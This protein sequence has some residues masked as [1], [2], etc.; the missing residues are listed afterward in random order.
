[1]DAAPLLSAEILSPA[2]AGEDLFAITEASNGEI[3]VVLIAVLERLL[4]GSGQAPRAL[5][6]AS[7][8]ERLEHLGDHLGTLA[9][10]TRLSVAILGEGK[11][12]KPS[13][14][15]EADVVLASPKTLLAAVPEESEG[16]SLG[17]FF[18]GLEILAL[19]GAEGLLRGTG[20]RLLRQVLALLPPHRQTFLFAARASPS[21][22][23]LAEEVLR[24]EPVSPGVEAADQREQAAEEAAEQVPAAAPAV[25][26]ERE[27]AVPEAA[28]VPEAVAVPEAGAVTG[29]VAEAEQGP[30][31]ASTEAR[32]VPQAIFFV[33]G[34]L[35]AEL[36]QELLIRSEVD[37]AVVFVRT[38]QRVNR[39]AEWLE[40]QGIT[41]ERVHGNRSLR[42]RNEALAALEQGR[43]RL[44]V[45]TEI[46]RSPDPDL[47][48]GVV[49]FDVPVNAGE[50]R[51]WRERLSAPEG[52]EGGLV[53]LVAP[54]EENHLRS[55]ERGLGEEL[56]RRVLDGFDY[57]SDAP[58][59]LEVRERMPPSKKEEPRKAGRARKGKGRGKP[60]SGGGGGGRKGSSPPPSQGSGAPPREGDEEARIRARAEEL[61]AQAV[62]ARFSP[63][64]MGMMDLRH[65]RP[66]HVSKGGGG[67]GGKS[68]RRRNKG[69]RRGG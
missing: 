49:F 10:H 7:G 59:A 30:G 13:L 66:D 54:R 31:E 69:S 50:Y 1:M 3:P 45:A 63:S 35:K 60:P 41:C 32:E 11:A 46:P 34:Q 48:F 51:S 24:R 25:P 9:R 18:R 8:K 38:R 36:L 42:Q 61:Q 20:G 57:E 67:G 39:L 22:R 19:E 53:I 23:I 52:G 29:E 43:V 17:G 37:R 55:V 44:L 47:S 68:G 58:D 40:R 27:L 21:V 64:R 12:S 28:A 56:P 2:L 33:R 65:D 14:L 16:S 26:E 15:G 6:L 62:A 4:Q 5:I